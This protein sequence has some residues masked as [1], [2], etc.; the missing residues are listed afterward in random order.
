MDQYCNFIKNHII[1]KIRFLINPLYYSLNIS[2]LEIQNSFYTEN[3]LQ[4][5]IIYNFIF[6]L[7]FFTL[8]YFNI[9]LTKIYKIMSL[10]E[11]Y[12]ALIYFLFLVKQ[13]SNNISK[14]IPFHLFYYYCHTFFV[15]LTSNH[16]FII[17]INPSNYLCPSFK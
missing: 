15:K 2:F 1:M 8:F 12:W 4:F 3:H 6:S 5:H 17:Y 13:N 14:K 10:P 16:I 7:N 9:F 11:Y